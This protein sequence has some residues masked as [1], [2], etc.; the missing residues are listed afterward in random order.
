MRNSLHIQLER[1]ASDRWARRGVRILMRSVW[2]GLSLCCLMLGVSLFLDVTPP[3]Q[4]VLALGLICIAG[5]A[6]FILRPR[7]SAVEVARRLDRR[8]RLNEQIA[9][10]LEIG[11]APTGIEVYLLDES[12]RAVSQIRRS[13]A[14]RRGF[15]WSEAAMILALLITLGG[16]AVMLGIGTAN[17]LA[18][19]EPLPALA[20]P[21][22]LAN[23]FPTEP[24]ST[25]TSPQPSPGPSNSTAPGAGDPAVMRALANALRDQSITRQAAEALD[26]GNLAGAAQSLRALADQAGRISQ[27]AR[28]DLGTALRQA[29]SQVQASSPSLADQLRTS[30]AGLQSGNDSQAAQSLQDLAGAVEK[31][32]SGQAAQ[33]GAGQQPGSTPDS[34]QT[35]GQG[36]GSG[37]GNSSLPGQQREQPADRLGVDGVPLELNAKG[38]GTA[39]TQ[40]QANSNAGG[41]GNGGAFSQG[42]SNPSTDPVLAADDPLRI[43][44]DLRDVVQDYFSP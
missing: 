34:S 25:P 3:W 15:P 40:G 37:A 10:A 2:L 24:V 9:T 30:A 16:L 42:G 6:I 18:A 29:A 38:D 26:Q 27:S 20:T 44:T 11:P 36:Q 5:G 23:A 41:T 39:A 32:G 4:W 35:S 1:L 28:N 19:P 13:V 7:M 17:P 12:R 21:Q 31:M 14:Q 8:F 43:P 33:T 22:S